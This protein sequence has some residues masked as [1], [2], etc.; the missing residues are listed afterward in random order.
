MIDPER[1]TEILIDCLLTDDEAVQLG[2]AGSVER[3]VELPECIVK[4]EG[5]I[6]G[7]GLMKARLETYRDEVKG[8]LN[9]LPDKFHD[10]GESFLAACADEKGNQWTG[11][12]KSVDELF[13][14][15]IGLGF[16]TLLGKGKLA[17]MMPGGLPY[18]QIK[19][20]RDVGNKHSV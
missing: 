9:Q 17:L 16:V 18:I 8:F 7:A 14:L 6:I 13:V 5:V 19:G 20:V 2:L 1:V 10:K 11:M 3:E 15:G 4:C 12:H